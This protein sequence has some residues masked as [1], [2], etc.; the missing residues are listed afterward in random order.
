MGLAGILITA[1][2][3]AEIFI[4]S[5]QETFPLPAIPGRP[6][7]WHTLT[8]NVLCG[9]V[10]P[11]TSTSCLELTQTGDGWKDYSTSLNQSRLAHSQWDSPSGIILLGGYDSSHST[12]LVSSAGTRSQF[13]LNAPVRLASD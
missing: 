3:Q 2:N 4:P 10:Y 13:R 7:V 5:T 12:E 11:G 6:R 8:G 1:Y 9:G